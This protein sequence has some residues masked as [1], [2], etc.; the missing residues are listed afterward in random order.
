MTAT[1]THTFGHYE[2]SLTRD[3][4]N[5]MVE[6]LGNKDEHPFLEEYLVAPQP[7]Q[8]HRVKRS[9]PLL[10]LEHEIYRATQATLRCG[11]VCGGDVVMLTN[12]LLGKVIAFFSTEVQHEPYIACLLHR[13]DHEGG[14]KYA[15]PGAVFV[16]PSDDVLGAAKWSD[17][18]G[19]VRVILPPPAVAM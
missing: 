14:G 12:R 6:R 1:A 11:L 13:M 8:A 4:L 15:Q 7:F 19:C 5:H 16:A 3:L 17:D 2:V 18:G 10:P 9:D